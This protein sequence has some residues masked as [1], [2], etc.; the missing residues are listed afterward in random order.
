[1]DTPSEIVQEV[2]VAK[3]LVDEKFQITA[4]NIKKVARDLQSKCEMLC[5]TL[6]VEGIFSTYYTRNKSHRFNLEY[7]I[8]SETI[9]QEL[10]TY[11][12]NQIINNDNT[13]HDIRNE[14]DVLESKYSTCLE[15]YG[16]EYVKGAYR[17]PF[18]ELRNIC[19]ESN[20]GDKISYARKT[21]LVD[22][23]QKGYAEIRNMINYVESHLTKTADRLNRMNPYRKRHGRVLDLIAEGEEYLSTIYV[24]C[25]NLKMEI[26]NE[27]QKYSKEKICAT[28]SHESYGPTAI[29]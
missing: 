23:L 12:T 24:R 14:L 19:N 5:R 15:S 17:N 16:V 26:T 7:T 6:Q 25:E 28:Q 2:T 8:S 29:L 21:A 4:G 20:I 1:M 18:N 13:L 22:I 27:Y 3:P 11:Y 10:K 9:S